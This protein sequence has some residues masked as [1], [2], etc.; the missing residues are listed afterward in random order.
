MWFLR[1]FHFPICGVYQ[2]LGLSLR[3]T[4][5]KLKSLSVRRGVRGTARKRTWREVERHAHDGA[6]RPLKREFELVIMVEVRIEEMFGS[7]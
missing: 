2:G 6:S 5:E 3:Q 4:C 1:R 7:D